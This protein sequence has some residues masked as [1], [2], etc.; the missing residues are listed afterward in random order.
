MED[1]AEQHELADEIA[2]A[3]SNPHGMHVSNDDEL[4]AE[5]ELLEQVSPYHIHIQVY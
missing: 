2:Q 5:L 3:I 4:L 1:I